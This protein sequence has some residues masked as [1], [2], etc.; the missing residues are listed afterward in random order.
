MIMSVFDCMDSF[1]KMQ[2][3]PR[4]QHVCTKVYGLDTGA[5]MSSTLGNGHLNDH[6]HMLCEVAEDNQ[7]HHPITVTRPNSNPGESLNGNR[8]LLHD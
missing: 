8:D 3:H 6:I 7:F 2:Y 4:E 1:Y 5:A